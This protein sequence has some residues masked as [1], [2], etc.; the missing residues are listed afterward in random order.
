MVYN[1]LCSNIIL[2][3]CQQLVTLFLISTLKYK[4]Y[5]DTNDKL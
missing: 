5:F 1:I 4:F 3:F 2:K